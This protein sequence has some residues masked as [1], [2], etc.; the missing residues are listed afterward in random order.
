MQPL[1]DCPVLGYHYNLLEHQIMK[2][3]NTM[4]FSKRV[5]VTV[6]NWSFNL[7]TNENAQTTSTITYYAGQ[8][9]SLVI[10]PS[11][12]GGADVTEIAA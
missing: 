2:E 8:T 7:D 4:K 11:V 1:Y 3:D 12:L 5:S 9:D 6:G 10:V